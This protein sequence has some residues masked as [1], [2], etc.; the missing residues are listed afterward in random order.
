M[1]PWDGLPRPSYGEV[2]YSRIRNE[3]VA[4]AE[5]WLSGSGR[6]AGGYVDPELPNGEDGSEVGNSVPPEQL[7][8]TL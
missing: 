1:Y 7:F 3:K 2:I 4:T 8:R 6:S 5:P